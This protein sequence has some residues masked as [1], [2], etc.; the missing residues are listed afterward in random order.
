MLT[1]RFGSGLQTDAEFVESFL[2]T[3]EKHPGCCDEVWLASNYGF[4]P[5]ETHRRTADTLTDV[6][7]K[8]RSAGLR[9][10]LQ[11]SN[12]IGHGQY[13]C[14]CDNSGLVYPGSPMEHMV[15]PDGTVADYCFCWNGEYFRSYVEAEM[16]E[17][18]RLRPYC[19]WVDDDIR[20]S[21]HAP[22]DFGCFC[23]G[24][25]A[26][27]NARYGAAFDRQTLV[28]AVNCG[29]GDW[30]ERW[31]AFVRGGIAELAE[32]IAATLCGL[33]PETYMGLQY[34]VHGGYTG[35]GYEYLFD[36]M[37]RGSGKNPKSRPGGILPVR[38][39]GLVGDGRARMI[40]TEL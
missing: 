24:C 25:I 18:A 3:V 32:L 17:Y 12:T 22:V 10:S 28:E 8:L 37:R 11:I 27:F 30:R 1:Q 2:R 14:S 9:V 33:S 26:K 31:V 5:L 20:A 7:E 29:G 38:R 16:R 21:N 35:Y 40:K 4:P 13:M 39:L 15:G 19:A 23:D 36:A 34:C 6:A